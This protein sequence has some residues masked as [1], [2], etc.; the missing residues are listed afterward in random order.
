MVLGY[1]VEEVFSSCFGFQA[2]VGLMGFRV[3]MFPLSKS[4]REALGCRVSA[5]NSSLLGF[6]RWSSGRL[7]NPWWNTLQPRVSMFV[8][9]AAAVSDQHN[10]DDYDCCCSCYG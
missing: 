8:H 3:L 2:L 5:N 10:D 1:R 9:T 7:E 6:G 4:S